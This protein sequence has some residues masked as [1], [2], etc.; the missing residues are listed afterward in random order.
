MPHYRPFLRH[1]RDVDTVLFSTPAI[2]L[3]SGPSVMADIY[4]YST[5][6]RGHPPGVPLGVNT[7]GRPVRFATPVLCHP[8]PK[9][10]FYTGL[11]DRP[12][13]VRQ[14]AG[15]EALTLHP[16]PDGPAGATKDRADLRESL[17]RSRTKNPA[18]LFSRSSNDRLTPESGLNRL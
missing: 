15:W 11:R 17:S 5:A 18:P 7:G 4:C 2:A 8:A 14:L 10:L 12:G 16:S 6:S 13:A 9:P 1:C 3:L